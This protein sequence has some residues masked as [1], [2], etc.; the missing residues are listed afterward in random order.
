LSFELQ[1][2][3]FEEHEYRMHRSTISSIVLRFEDFFLFAWPL[4]IS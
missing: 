1:K 2:D 4:E 3:T